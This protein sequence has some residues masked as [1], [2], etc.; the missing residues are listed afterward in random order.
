MCGIGWDGWGAKAGG[1]GGPC[2]NSSSMLLSLSEELLLLLLEMLYAVG[3]HLLCVG[4]WVWVDECRIGGH[5]VQRCLT[6]P[7]LHMAK[8]HHPPLYLL[9][10]DKL[11]RSVLLGMVEVCLQALLQCHELWILL[12]RLHVDCVALLTP[13]TCKADEGLTYWYLCC[14]LGGG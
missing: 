5:D 7:T 14:L 9:H 8:Q 12:H 3:N 6:P 11:L 2:S 10:V 1:G 4:G 13:W